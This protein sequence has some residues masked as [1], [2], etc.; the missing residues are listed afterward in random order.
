MAAARVH[1]RVMG[2]N[3][4]VPT[5]GPVNLDNLGP[6]NSRI[7]YLPSCTFPGCRSVS[8]FCFFLTVEVSC[9][10]KNSE[11]FRIVFNILT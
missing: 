1:D 3:R 6:E 10:L 11:I 5:H 4:P 8:L 7:R 9:A 2:G